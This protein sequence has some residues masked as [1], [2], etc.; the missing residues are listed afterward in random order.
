MK[1]IFQCLLA[2]LLVLMLSGCGG[3]GLELTQDEMLE[4][5]DSMWLSIEEN[6]AHM[7]VAQRITGKDFNQIKAAY[8]KKI[9]K[10]ISQE[11]FKAIL[12]LCLDEFD[13]IGQMHLLD[14]DEY[15]YYYRY[16]KKNATSA[17]HLSYLFDILNY[18]QSKNF[19]DYPS[20]GGL[21]KEKTYSKNVETAILE[22]DQIAYIQIHSMDVSKM[23]KDGAKIRKF[24]EKVKDYKAVIFDIQGV[25]SGSEL[26]WRKYIVPM[27]LEKETTFSIY[28]LVKGGLS[29]EYL[30][31]EQSLQPIGNL[32]SM[33]KLLA[34]DVS[35]ITDYVKSDFVVPSETGK[36]LFDGALYLLVD[37]KVSGPAETFAMFAKEKNFATLVGENTAGDTR[38]M[39]PIM[40]RLPNS[41]LIM[42]FEASHELN[43]D[44]SS[45]IEF[46]T[47][48]DI[49]KQAGNDALKQAIQ[50]IHKRFSLPD[51]EPVNE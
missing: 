12:T 22:E 24:L 43:A 17:E 39:E 20:D 15:T 30:H 31:T 18:S 7:A 3:D 11:Q 4:D 26:Y 2:G 28:G 35:G 25:T 8:R 51:D 42:R 29:K 38:R 9:T 46:G 1:K 40:V 37:E 23:E 50:S 34:D 16:Y 14:D 13:G 32:K 36:K 48:P 47:S 19:Y 44:G 41:G 5:Y 27:N 45:N 49:Y 10:D 6:Y 21:P 33:D